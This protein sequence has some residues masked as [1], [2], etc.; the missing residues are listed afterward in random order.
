MITVSGWR[1]PVGGAKIDWNSVNNADTA[2]GK[3][4]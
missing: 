2:D 4:S 3:V 1:I